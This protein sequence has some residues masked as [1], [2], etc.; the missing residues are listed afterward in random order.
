MVT[1]ANNGGFASVRT[2]NYEPQL[3]WGAYEGVELRLRG[4]GLRYKVTLRTD[5]AWDSV[6]YNV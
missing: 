6:G 1:T 5:A 4:N 2:K 3:D